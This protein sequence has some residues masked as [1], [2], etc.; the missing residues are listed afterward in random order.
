MIYN[1]TIQYEDIVSP[2]KSIVHI[3]CE[4]CGYTTLHAVPKILKN[5]VYYYKNIRCN[6]CKFST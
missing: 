3:E 6:Q 2:D 5:S 4:S 1:K